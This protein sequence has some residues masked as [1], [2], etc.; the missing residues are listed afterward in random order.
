MDCA[1]PIMN[2][3]EATQELIELMESGEVQEVPIIACTAF[4][5]EEQK[6]MCFE[7][8]MKAFINKP[9][10]IDDLKRTLQGFGIVASF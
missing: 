5:D 3:F 4:T 9:V 2:G 8:G 1:M 7:C 6:T 10:I